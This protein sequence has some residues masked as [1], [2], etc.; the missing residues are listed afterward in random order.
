MSPDTGHVLCVVGVFLSSQ[1]ITL[2]LDLLTLLNFVRFCVLFLFWRIRYFI[3]NRC[4]LILMMKYILYWLFC[5]MLNCYCHCFASRCNRTFK[6]D[7][8]G[9]VLIPTQSG[10]YLQL[11]N[12]KVRVMLEVM[13]WD[14]SSVYKAHIC[15]RHEYLQ[16]NLLYIFFVIPKLCKYGNLEWIVLTYHVFPLISIRQRFCEMCISSLKNLSSQR[17]KY[18]SNIK[19]KNT[20]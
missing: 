17:D 5:L 8:N 20:T 18:F 10:L 14:S 7:V 19:H 11:L 12:V 15:D 6:D 9:F 1:R 16:Y 2:L 13:G 3:I 4:Y